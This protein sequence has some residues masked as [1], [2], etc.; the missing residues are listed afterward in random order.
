[1]MANK[2]RYETDSKIGEGTYS[3]I[4]RG[5]DTKTGS[6]RFSRPPDNRHVGGAEEDAHQEI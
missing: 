6:L 1:M 4:Y 2:K 5:I 3:T